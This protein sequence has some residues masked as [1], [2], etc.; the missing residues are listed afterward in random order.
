MNA[1]GK[2]NTPRFAMLELK[3]TNRVRDLVGRRDL[4]LRDV[5]VI[6]TLMSYTSSYSGRIQVSAARIAQDLQIRESDARASLSR[7][8]KHLVLRQ[9]KDR[10]TGERYYR[11]NPWMVLTNSGG[12][13]FGLACREFGEA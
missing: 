3:E 10:D 6:W 4:E 13:L 11:L 12:S 2:A 5:A 8:K 1:T 9:I 7:L